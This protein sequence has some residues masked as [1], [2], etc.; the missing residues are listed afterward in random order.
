[1]KAEVRCKKVEMMV[2][3]QKRITLNTVHEMM[4]GMS[5]ELA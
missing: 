5:V 3:K 2:N 4:D 1:M